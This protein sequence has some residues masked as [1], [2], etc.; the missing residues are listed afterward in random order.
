VLREYVLAAAEALNVDVSFILLPMLSALGSA[1]G[2]SRSIRLKAAHCE[3]PIIWTVIIGR[4]GSRKSPALRFGCEA[5]F[6]HERELVRQNKQAFEQY[7]NDFVEW[8]SKSR[9]QRGPKPQPKPSF[10]CLMDDLTLEALGDALQTN[11][12]GVIVVKDEL[13][14]W[15]ESHDQYRAGKGADVSRWLSLH[16]GSFLALDR[17][18]DH[19]RYRIDHPR[20][21]ITGGIQPGV[22][23]RILNEDFFER[24][25]PARFLFGAPPI[26]A[27][28]WSET[29]V[30]D[31]LRAGLRELFNDLYLLQ[32]SQEE[33]TLLDL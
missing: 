18:T 33:P 12:R 6:E 2:N 13:S 11:P 28:K 8:E 25:L 4:S 30:P 26:A 21:C 7:Q 32:P 17:R 3:P 10:T 31:E 22:L 16:I 9:E 1:I 24:G 29:I 15:F 20:V 5:A 23:K 14:H 27:P 19:R